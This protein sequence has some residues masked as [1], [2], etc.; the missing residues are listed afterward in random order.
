MFRMP[1]RVFCTSQ[2]CRRLSRASLE[3]RPRRFRPKGPWHVRVMEGK[4][5]MKAQAPEEKCVVGFVVSAGGE[6][7]KRDFAS[8]RRHPELASG[9]VK[10]CPR[11]HHDIPFLTTFALATTFTTRHLTVRTP[12][13]LQGSHLPYCR[14]QILQ[15][16]VSLTLYDGHKSECERILPHSL[17]TCEREFASCSELPY[18]N[19]V[20]ILS[21]YQR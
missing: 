9:V 19:S 11:S 13:Y 8:V 21:D 16:E 15:H 3:F 14:P 12:R 18:D 17:C 20:P 6:A 5:S 4:G 10:P 1:L 2:R 7:P